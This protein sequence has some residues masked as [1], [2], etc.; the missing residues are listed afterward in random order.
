MGMAVFLEQVQLP[1][2]CFLREILFWIAFQRL[3]TAIYTMDG[4]EWR[5]SS[6]VLCEYHIDTGDHVDAIEGLRAGIPADPRYEAHLKN[7]PTIMPVATLDRLLEFIELD[8]KERAQLLKE[9]ETAEEFEAAC[10]A[11]DAQYHKAIEYPSSQ[12]FVALR[13]GDLRTTGR[14]LPSLDADEADRILA[15]EDR[16]LLNIQPSDIPA[17]FWSLSGIDFHNS[18]AQNDTAHYCHVTARLAD[19]LD[20]FPG[21]R[22]PVSGLERIGGSYVLNER[23]AG[24]VAKPQRGRPSYPWDKFNLEV[25]ALLR[26]NALP[27]KKEAAIQHFQSWFVRE[28]DAQVSR[29]AIGEKLKPYYDR[30]MRG[31][32]R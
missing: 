7:S 5:E 30:F 31:A 2:R 4:E 29:A 19:V 10:A 1:D 25:A 23:N 3:P 17:A 6:E 27:A 26:A 24:L 16:S 32:D 11:W 28:F 21:E 12:I 20:L 9:R 15:A 22:T 18:A 14:L 8:R 13:S